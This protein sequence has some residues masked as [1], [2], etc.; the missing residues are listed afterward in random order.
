[1]RFTTFATAIAIAA[2]SALP[3]AADDVTEAIEEAVAAYEE[4]D[5]AYA[6]ES[7]EF[8]AQLIGQMKTGTLAAL[9]PEALDGWEAGETETETMGAAMFGGGSTASRTYAKDGKVV[10]IEYIADSPILAQMAAM[11]A[12]PA[13]MGGKAVR[14]GRQRAVIDDD[15]TIQFL[16]DNRIMVRVGGDA[17]V[18]DKTAYAKTID[19]RALK[20]H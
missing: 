20:N 15:G 19:A 7:L 11:F 16:V 17:S 4:G 3:A 1:M 14:I 9:L 13:M 5:L 10:E 2:M 8:A 12:N 6:K 18:E